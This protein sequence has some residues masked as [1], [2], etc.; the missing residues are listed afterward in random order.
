MGL[1]EGER[2]AQY[3]LEHAAFEERMSTPRHLASQSVYEKFVEL[4]GEK[5]AADDFAQVVTDAVAD[6]LEKVDDLKNGIE[7]A[8]DDLD[9]D[10]GNIND[11]F[12][13]LVAE[14][15]EQPEPHRLAIDRARVQV[16]GLAA[17]AT[18]E[19]RAK[20]KELEADR[21]KVEEA[22]KKLQDDHL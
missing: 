1:I 10:E 14:L 12:E 13:D 8:G 9:D 18:R 22:L 2:E 5:V 20:L 19:V 3:L 7:V 15:G 6:A 21:A 17:D 11:V 4:V 16:L